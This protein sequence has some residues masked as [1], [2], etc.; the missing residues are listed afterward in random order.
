[1]RSHT[2]TP[3]FVYLLA[4]S[5]VA[6]IAFLTENSAILRHLL[7]K[8]FREIEAATEGFD[9]AAALGAL[10]RAASDLEIAL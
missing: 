3:E 4:R 8:H 5:D 6:A 1:M 10:K 9:F 7:G 2:L